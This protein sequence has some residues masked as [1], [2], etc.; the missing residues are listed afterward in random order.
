MAKLTFVCES[1]REALFD[2]SIGLLDAADD[3]LILELAQTYGADIIDHEC[4][5]A[6]C[7]DMRCACACQRQS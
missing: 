7:P 6:E 4:E 2:E 1:C 5:A 3:V